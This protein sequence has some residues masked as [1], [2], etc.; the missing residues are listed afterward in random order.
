MNIL[1]RTSLDFHSGSP[2]RYEVIDDRSIFMF[3]GHTLK[4]G[5]AN[6]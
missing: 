5:I 2:K 1:Y 4:L 3:Y 6:L